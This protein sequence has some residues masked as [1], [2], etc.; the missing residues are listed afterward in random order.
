[1]S[2]SVDKIL[3]APN[4]LKNNH[5]QNLLQGLKLGIATGFI[6]ATAEQLNNTINQKASTMTAKDYVNGI[7]LGG[8]IGG[9]VYGTCS[10]I[11]PVWRDITEYRPDELPFLTASRYLHSH[12]DTRDDLDLY[13]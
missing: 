1:M 6:V 12:H 13:S 10:L 11:Q 5:S 9:S 7:I 8:I 4:S 2:L 3:K